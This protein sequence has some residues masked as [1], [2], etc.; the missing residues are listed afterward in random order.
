MVG[1]GVSQVVDKA[2]SVVSDAGTV[3]SASSVSDNTEASAQTPVFQTSLPPI[4]QALSTD[5]EKAQ[6]HG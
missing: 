2:G 4:I 3:S 6:K 5:S 1:F